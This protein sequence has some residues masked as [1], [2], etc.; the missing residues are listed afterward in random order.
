MGADWPMLTDVM[1]G[2]RL[3]WVIVQEKVSWV[4][5]APS[6]ALTSTGYGLPTDAVE[7]TVPLIR[8]VPVSIVR[9]G[10]RPVAPYEIP[11]ASASV[12]DAASET[13]PASASV[14]FCR[15]CAKAGAVFATVAWEVA[16]VPSA[17][18]SFG[19]TSTETVSPL[20]PL[21]AMPRPNVSVRAVLLVNVRLT[22][23]FTFQTKV[24]E[25]ACPSESALVAVAVSVSFVFGAF[26]LSETVAVG[27]VFAGA[28]CIWSLP[29][30]VNVPEPAGMKRQSKLVACSVSFRT[31][32][33]VPLPALRCWR[34]PC[35]RV[36]NSA[37]PV[38]TMISRT[39]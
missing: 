37:P 2:G 35:R 19:V 34:R 27:S 3:G 20:S 8:P 23:P 26:E 24:S 10:G 17:T 33:V 4:V 29:E 21:P 31:P 16:G 32:F 28:L 9:P 38:P 18:P 15:S 36:L 5:A 6:L 12:A 14:R 39:P 7:E 25:T 30:S 1:L 22:A 13:V 11:S